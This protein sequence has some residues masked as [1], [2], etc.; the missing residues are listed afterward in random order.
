M[1]SLLV[2]I[3]R[4]V[5]GRMSRFFLLLGAHGPSLKLTLLQVKCEMNFSLGGGWFIYYKLS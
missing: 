3:S 1:I 5:E 2:F 4:S